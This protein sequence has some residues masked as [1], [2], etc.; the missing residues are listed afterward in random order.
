MRYVRDGAVSRRQHPDSAAWRCRFCMVTPD[1]A[2]Y[3]GS[4][5]FTLGLNKYRRVGDEP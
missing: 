3:Y 4:A 1:G 5:Q 2:V